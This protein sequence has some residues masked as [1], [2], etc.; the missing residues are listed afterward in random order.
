MRKAVALTCAAITAATLVSTQAATAAQYAP[1]LYYPQVNHSI[2]LCGTHDHT[3]VGPADNSIQVRNTFWKGT[4]PTCIR[5]PFDGHAGFT[6]TRTPSPTSPRQMVTT[7]P[8]IFRGCVWN[9]CTKNTP[10]PARADQLRTVISTWSTISTHRVAKNVRVRAT[11]T[12][13]CLRGSR[14]TVT[15]VHRH[16]RI[17]HGRVVITKTRTTTTTC[18]VHRV[19]NAPLPGTYNTAYDL[20]FGKQSMTQGHADGAELMVWLNHR[21][22]CCILR[23]NAPIVRINGVQY[24]FQFWHPSDPQF[25]GVSWNYIQFRRV[26]QTTHVTNLNL[27]PF[28]QY[29]EQAHRAQGQPN[30]LISRR[31]WLESLEGGFEIWNGGVG[32]RT[33]SFAA[34]VSTG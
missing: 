8:S 32:L 9:M 23:R 31:W 20:W 5:T 34:G 18:L 33:T 27:K 30:A 19:L 29:A 28:I 4:G 2:T 21:G 16:R 13:A 1:H 26:V 15:V 22:G 3:P 14:R 12:T 10:L 25:P 11:G 7:F 24:Y 6:V 17:V